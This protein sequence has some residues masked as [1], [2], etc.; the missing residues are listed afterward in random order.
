MIDGQLK[1]ESI[2]SWNSK[3]IEEQ[4]ANS[5][6]TLMNTFLNRYCIWIK[7]HRTISRTERELTVDEVYEDERNA[8][9]DYLKALADE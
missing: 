4:W 7:W 5:F 8:G 3:G 1:Q 9:I 6:D 2:W